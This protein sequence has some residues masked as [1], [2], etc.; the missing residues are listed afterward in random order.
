MLSSRE[1]LRTAAVQIRDFAPTSEDTDKRL[2]PAP[3]R[4]T[5]GC[6]REAAVRRDSEGGNRSRGERGRRRG[7]TGTPTQRERGSA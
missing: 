2:A 4:P 6:D 5:A 7:Q 3:S 1:L